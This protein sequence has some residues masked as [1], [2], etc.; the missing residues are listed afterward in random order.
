MKIKDERVYYVFVT[1]PGEYAAKFDMVTRQE[2]E[3][4]S[5]EIGL[6]DALKTL[7]VPAGTPFAS[8]LATNVSKNGVAIAPLSVDTDAFGGSAYVYS[9]FQPGDIVKVGV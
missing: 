9:G 8:S 4:I 2:G 6:P 5:N 3:S 1:S 7:K